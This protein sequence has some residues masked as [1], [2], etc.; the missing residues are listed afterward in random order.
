MR[1][2]VWDEVRGEV[3]GGVN[4]E[5]RDEVGDEVGG[6]VWGEVRRGVRWEVKWD[7]NRRRAQ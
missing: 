1:D 4:R 6:G 2:T 5:V 3:W 7:F